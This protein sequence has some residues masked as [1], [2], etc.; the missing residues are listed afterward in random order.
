MKNTVILVTREGLGSTSDE[1]DFGIEMLD[2]F[3]HTLESQTD[4]PTAICFYTEG[5]KLL[6]KGSS[7]LAGLFILKGLG[8]RIVACKS[9]AIKYDVMENLGVGKLGGMPDIVALMSEADKVITV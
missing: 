1:R 5:V 6:A 7:V 8:V 3:F 4:R 9:C 2:N